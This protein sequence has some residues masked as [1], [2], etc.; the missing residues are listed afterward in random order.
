MHSKFYRDKSSKMVK[1]FK[2]KSEEN[3]FIPQYVAFKNQTQVISGIKRPIIL[4]SKINSI[5]MKKEASQ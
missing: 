2:K 1:K 4:R 3:S 5:F